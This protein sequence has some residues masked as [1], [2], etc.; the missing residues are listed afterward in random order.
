MAPRPPGVAL[1]QQQQAAQRQAAAQQAVEVG[2]P[3]GHQGLAV[4]AGA[5]PTYDALVSTAV[6]LKVEHVVVLEQV[7][8][9]SA[10]GPAPTSKAVYFLFKSSLISG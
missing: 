9:P 7:G 6:D 2:V 4:Q 3:A 5:G 10:A 1:E 8:G